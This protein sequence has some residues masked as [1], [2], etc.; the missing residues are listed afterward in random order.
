[1]KQLLLI[2][3]RR[4]RFDLCRLL[5][6]RIQAAPGHFMNLSYAKTSNMSNYNSLKLKL[7]TGMSFISILIPVF[8]WVLWDHCFKSQDNQADRVKMYHSYFPEFL[9]GRYTISFISLVF[10]ILGV[11]LAS[12]YFQRRTSYLKV[13]NIIVFAVAILMTMLSLFSL[14]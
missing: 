2:C 11:I 9:H 12:V 7:L 4:K 5:S 13:I 1:M 10:S 6:S 3:L 14:M 8:L